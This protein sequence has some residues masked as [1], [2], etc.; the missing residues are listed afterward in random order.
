MKKPVSVEEGERLASELGAVA[1]LECSAST[2]EGVKN[3]VDKVTSRYI[4]TFMDNFLILSLLQA[5]M[6]A[7]NEEDEG[8]E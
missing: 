2:Q 5:L 7:L 4:L 3:V 1:Y 6:A 8:M